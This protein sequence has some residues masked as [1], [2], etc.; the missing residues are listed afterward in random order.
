MG[1]PPAFLDGDVTALLRVF[2]RNPLTVIRFS[3]YHLA[4]LSYGD[5]NLLSWNAILLLGCSQT[6]TKP[7]SGST[8]FSIGKCC[9]QKLTSL[10]RF[11]RLVKQKQN[12][13]VLLPPAFL[14][15]GSE[16]KTIDQ[17]KIMFKQ[18]KVKRKHP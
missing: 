16:K 4:F 5:T 17:I 14:D 12:Q 9:L 1:L 8:D 13:L 18:L 6:K 7:S 15:G 11:S 10:H 2:E 3:P